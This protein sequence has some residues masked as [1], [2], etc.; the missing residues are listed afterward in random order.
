MKPTRTILFSGEVFFD[1]LTHLNRIRFGPW[2]PEDSKMVYFLWNPLDFTLRLCVQS[3]SWEGHQ[4][5]KLH[6]RSP[7]TKDKLGPSLCLE[8]T[9]EEGPVT[10][11]LRLNAHLRRLQQI[12]ED[13]GDVGACLRIELGEMKAEHVGWFDDLTHLQTIINF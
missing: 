13:D 5:A 10:R 8:D 7:S 1:M 4:E 6:G 12:G 3:E 2:F 9:G 11:Y